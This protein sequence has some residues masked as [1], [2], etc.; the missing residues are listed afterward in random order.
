MSRERQRR[1]EPDQQASGKH[2]GEG[3]NRLR[4]H[5]EEIRRREG[6]AV[7]P[8]GARGGAG[9]HQLVLRAGSAH[10]RAQAVAAA[11]RARRL[12]ESRCLAHLERLLRLRDCTR[13][14]A[15]SPAPAVRGNDL[16][17]RRTG[18]D[19]GVERRRAEESRS[20]GRRARFSPFRST[21]GTSISTAPAGTPRA[22]SP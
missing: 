3:R 11:R 12:P 8:V 5:G 1:R 21:P 18:F 20:S 15:R 17:P 14:G 19:G 6:N 16:R 22:L 9:D 2:H 4:R 13:Q 10:G 7:H